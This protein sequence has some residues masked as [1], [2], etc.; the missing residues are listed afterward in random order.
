MSTSDAS[1]EP[2]SIISSTFSLLRSVLV[3]WE[4]LL[5]PQPQTEFKTPLHRR[6]RNP[7]SCSKNDE[8]WS[9]CIKLLLRL[10]LARNL[11]VIIISSLLS[12]QCVLDTHSVRQMQWQHLQLIAFSLNYLTLN[13]HAFISIPLKLYLN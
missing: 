2:I 3:S 12:A 8:Q 9:K 10:C 7:I 5:T 11:T 6:N 13:S 4:A 1:L